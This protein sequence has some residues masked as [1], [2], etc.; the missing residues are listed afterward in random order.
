LTPDPKGPRAFG[1]KVHEAWF[2]SRFWAPTTIPKYDGELITVFGW[3]TIGSRATW[4][5]TDDLFIIKNLPL[6]LTDSA[7]T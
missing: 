1:W 5:V 7:R 4:G 3:R 6:Y 2:P